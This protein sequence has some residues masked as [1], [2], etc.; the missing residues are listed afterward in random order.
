MTTAIRT[1]FEVADVDG[2]RTLSAGKE[3]FVA[4]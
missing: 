4:Y 3:H 2:D 1:F